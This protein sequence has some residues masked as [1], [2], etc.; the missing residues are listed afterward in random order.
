M[1]LIRHRMLLSLIQK[2]TPAAETI[3]IYDY[4]T[5]PSVINGTVLSGSY[6]ELGS[7]GLKMRIRGSDS[8][9]CIIGTY[10]L[11]SY[12]ML[13]VVGGK[14]DYNI[15]ALYVEVQDSSGA[16]LKTL[17]LKSDIASNDMSNF[18][19]SSGNYSTHYLNVSD[20]KG[21]CRIKL[22]ISASGTTQTSLVAFKRIALIPGA[23]S[24]PYI[25]RITVTGTGD[26]STGSVTID[27][28]SAYQETVLDLPHGAHT[29]V[30]IAYKI[31]ID[32]TEHNAGSD[33]EA[34]LQM[35][36]TKSGNITINIE[37]YSDGLLF[38]ADYYII[39]I[40]GGE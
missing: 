1:D 15:T 35:T 29:I 20:I 39:T 36:I 31:I 5:A 18:T 9:T 3:V 34:L 6:T 12:T 17:D 33:T 26:I 21:E 38:G 4:D 16:T 10:D 23:S 7:A 25:D 8:M 28:V 2:S 27:G 30:A 37:H 32:G 40:S 24:D 14:K 19:T 13:E 11:T 22:Y